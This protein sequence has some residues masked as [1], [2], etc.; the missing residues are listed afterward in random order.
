MSLKK[1]VAMSLA[2]L[3]L[4]SA[5][6]AFAWGEFGRRPEKAGNRFCKEL[7]L[8]AEQKEKFLAG[9]KALKDAEKPLIED[10]KKLFE[11]L[12]AEIK[13]DLPNKIMIR[14]TLKQ[15]EANNAEMR[16]KRLEH[17]IE[18]RKELTPEQKEKLKTMKM[19]P[20]RPRP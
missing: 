15:I 4:F 11:K 10:N 13:K 16:F 7:G 9:D 14:G 1:L 17:L 19:G 5:S 8:T 20:K 18:F 6:S 3:V 12:D 2:L